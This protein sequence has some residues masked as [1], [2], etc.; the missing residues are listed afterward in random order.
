MTI[1]YAPEISLVHLSSTNDELTSSLLVVDYQAKE[2]R[3]KCRVV[4][5]PFDKIYWMKN[6]MKL[7]NNQRVHQ[8]VSTYMENYIISELVLKDFSTDDQGEYSCVA[9]NL[10]GTS[11]KTIQLIGTT[12]TS[13]IITTTTVITTT[14]MPSDFSTTHFVISR[15]K[16]PKHT[17]TTTTTI[18]VAA[19]DDFFRSTELLREM[20]ISSSSP[21]SSSNGK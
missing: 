14:T 17:R 7:M 9:S 5:N 2:I 3:L 21:S 1:Q 4:M 10:L 16:R 11:S 6:S 12:S 15:R 13:T 19:Q 18:A 20:T 8:Y